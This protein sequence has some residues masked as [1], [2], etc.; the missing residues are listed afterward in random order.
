MGEGILKKSGRKRNLSGSSSEKEKDP[1]SVF[2]R[3]RPIRDDEESCVQV[4]DGQVLELNA[5]QS[6][7]SKV[8][9]LRCTYNKVF[10]DDM[11]QEQ[12]FD[13]IGIPLV[14]DLL[15]GKNALCFMYGI[16]GSGKTYTMNGKGTDS[17][18]LP[19]TLDTVF[20]SIGSLQTPRCTFKPTGYNSFGVNSEE[21]ASLDA[22]VKESEMEILRNNTDIG[23][24]LH[25]RE[26]K[27]LK[28]NEDN[29]YA[30]F[31][32][33]VEIYNN[34][35]FDLLEDISVDAFRQ[36]KPPSSKVLREDNRR[37]MFVHEVVELEVKSTEEAYTLFVMGQ[38]RR[39]TAL[40]LMNAE[41][42]RSHCV[43]TLRLVQAP[44]GPSGDSILKDPKMFAV[45]Q[46]SLC[47]LAGSERTSR[48]K[49][50]G[51]KI[52]Q[53][54]HINNSL[55]TLRSCLE[56]LRENQK[57]VESGGNGGRMVP[58]RDSK[59]T[60]LFKN[61]FD[62]D[63]R[64]N[65]IVCLNPRG[66]DFDESIHVMKFAEMTQEV[67]V[68]R[69]E[70]HKMDTGLTEG[71]GKMAKKFKEMQETTDTESNADSVSSDMLAPLQMFPSWPTHQLAGYND[72]K[73]FTI[74]LDHL[75]ERMHLR[76]SLLTDRQQKETELR[77][78]LIQLEEDKVHLTQALEEQ[79]SL[80]NDREKEAKSY[81][82]RIR[83]VTEKCDGLQ[84]NSH[85]FESQIKQLQ[86]ELSSQK[87][88][89][90]KEKQE[91]ARLKKTL[92]DLTSNERLRWE[93]E[94]DKR[95]RDKEMEMEEQV[96]ITFLKITFYIFN[97]VSIFNIFS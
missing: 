49:T 76:K 45:S 69:T 37:N 63:G 27:S 90:I 89:L 70:T 38:N 78:M 56:V 46:L 95:V 12:V 54:G 33:F 5:P 57:S 94:C 91:K 82:K 9:Q 36:P 17:G 65:M 15:S 47:D 72:N 35:V 2:C 68:A 28:V 21:A 51:E 66:E 6:S 55:M 79:R 32:S 30:I 23:E 4:L 92:K 34:S 1:I 58:Y 29:N 93:K 84:R 74:L 44:L 62:G 50:D 41:S 87:D 3:I 77:N 16:T 40:T 96:I 18:V 64:V 25:E 97:T 31:I 88:L 60:H 85:T 71:R 48:T 42:S 61:Y 75:K 52:R 10:T 8:Q 83:Q 59:L 67:K 14:Q 22:K 53:A 86:S 43:F 24:I 39:K 13:H 11:N 26:V 73:T 19:R 81:E 80:L 20:N 7:N